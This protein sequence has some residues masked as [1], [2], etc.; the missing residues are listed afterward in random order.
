MSYPPTTDDDDLTTPQTAPVLDDDALTTPHNPGM[1]MGLTAPQAPLSEPLPVALWPNTSP[2]LPDGPSLAP[3]PPLRARR[4]VVRAGITLVGVL[5]L[6]ALV[7]GV[8]FVASHRSGVAGASDS[9][10]TAAGSYCRALQGAQYPQGYALWD[11]A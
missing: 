6:M 2:Y 8:A 9:A 4:N 11:A 7:A 3:P 1:D 5:T 10:A